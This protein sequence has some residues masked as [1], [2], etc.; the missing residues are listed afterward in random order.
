MTNSVTKLSA[1]ALAGVLAVAAFALFAQPASAERGG[2]NNH[3]GGG[4]DKTEIEVENKETTVKNDVSV[5]ANTG[6]NSADGGDGGRGGDGGDASRG[7]GGHGGHGGFGADGGLIETGVATAYGTVANDVNSTNIEVEA[8]GCD[9]DPILD[10]FARFFHFNDSEKL[11]IEIENKDTEVKTDLDVRA[12]TGRNYADGGD[13]ARGGHGGD[14]LSDR[15]PMKLWKLW[16]FMDQA[17][18]TAGHGGHGA[19]GGA[20][21]SVISGEAY[22]DGLVTN[23]VNRSVVR[24]LAGEDDDNGPIV[25]PI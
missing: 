17:P 1:F 21:G 8:C 4:G 9:E 5:T 20:G 25:L 7:A 11:E 22:A 6:G 18:N 3:R 10:R 16:L 15:G 2:D 23:V 13:G 19:T 12:N 24:V 14:A